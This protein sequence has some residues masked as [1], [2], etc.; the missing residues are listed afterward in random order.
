VAVPHFKDLTGQPFD[1]LIVIERAP[2][3]GRHVQWRCQ[4]QCG[5][6]TL[7]L[8]TNL[9]SRHTKSCGCLSAERRAANLGPRT[10]GLSNTSEYDIWCNIKSRCLNPRNQA[11]A[12]YGARGIQICDAWRDSFE[13]FLQDM[14]PR[15]SPQHTVERQNNSLGY[16]KDNC[17]WA[18]MK[19]Q[20]RNSHGNHS[21]T[22]N[23]TT[24]CAAAWAEDHRLGSRTVQ[25][26]LRRGWSIER[27]LSMPPRPYPRRKSPLAS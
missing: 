19:T 11:Y 21:I 13:T 10:H 5:T 14:G 4:C 16:S 23:G 7:V 12:Y 8:A 6:V 27:A 2:N 17:I 20:N 24:Q 3:R 22:L 1:R 15:P 25:Q 9:L 18:T 26:R